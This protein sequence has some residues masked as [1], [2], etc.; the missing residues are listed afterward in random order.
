MDPGEPA[1]SRGRPPNQ[2]VGTH[3]AFFNMTRLAAGIHLIPAHFV[4]HLA[5]LGT[6]LTQLTVVSS[7]DLL[8]GCYQGPG[9]ALF[10]DTQE[11][12]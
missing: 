2:Q 3:A 5:H 10:A 9:L 6:S 8:W 12:Y 7:Y 1:L 4:S 11:C